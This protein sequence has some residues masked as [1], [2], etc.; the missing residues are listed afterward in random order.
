MLQVEEKHSSRSSNVL[1]AYIFSGTD[2]GANIEI[3]EH[4]GED[5]I[6]IFGAKNEEIPDA[7]RKMKA[8]ASW[9][10]R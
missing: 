2:D 9:D 1:D 5:N 10:S 3:K 6:F 8:G 4:V 7:T